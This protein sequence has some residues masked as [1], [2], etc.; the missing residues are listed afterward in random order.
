MNIPSLQDNVSA[1]DWQ[2]RVDLA[3]SAQQRGVL[4]IN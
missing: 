3:V 2:L 1:E 4:P